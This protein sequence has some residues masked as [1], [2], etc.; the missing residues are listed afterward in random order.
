MPWSSSAAR[1][2]E[3]TLA[4]VDDEE[5]GEVGVF[6]AAPRP[7]THDL[8]HRLE[9]VLTAQATHLVVAVAL[10]DRQ[11]VLE[12]HDAGDNLGAV[13]VRDVDA[14]EALRVTP[15]EP[16]APQA[17]RGNLRGAASAGA[18]Y[19][20]AA[21]LQASSTGGVL[22][23]RCGT[24]TADAPR[25]AWL[26]QQLASG[27]CHSMLGGKRI[28]SGR[29]PRGSRR[30]SAGEVGQHFAGGHLE[31]RPARSAALFR[32]PCAGAQHVDLDGR[33]FAVQAHHVAWTKSE[34][35]RAGARA[36]ARSRAS[37]RGTAPRPRTRARGA[38]VMR[39]RARS[40]ARGPPAKKRRR[41]PRRSRRTSR[42]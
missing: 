20:C 38:L 21:F 27:S 7:S 4:A 40:P 12:A 35:R 13:Q 10:L 24:R 29:R 15:Q 32:P 30:S 37:D 5:V 16:S 18:R 28:S 36:S 25:A 42:R 22:S 34:R 39:P 11:A 17:R 8:V 41:R 9:V 6:E 23:P 31:R 14:L 3:L 2:A 19:A 1:A 26:E 33:A